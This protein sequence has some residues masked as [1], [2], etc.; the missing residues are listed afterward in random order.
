MI[1]LD[2]AEVIRLRAVIEPDHP[3]NSF[4]PII[5]LL[6]D[7]GIR[8]ANCSAAAWSCSAAKPCRQGRLRSDPGPSAAIAD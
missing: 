7:L 8:A 3:E 4:E 2:D 6:L 5:R 1:G